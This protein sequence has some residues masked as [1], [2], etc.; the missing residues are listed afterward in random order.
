MTL[1]VWDSCRVPL[2]SIWHAELLDDASRSG[3]ILET[4]VLIGY[5]SKSK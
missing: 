2:G 1:A 3:R 5:A 4:V